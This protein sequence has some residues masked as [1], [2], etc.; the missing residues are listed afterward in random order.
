M[1]TGKSDLLIYST[2]QNR[3]GIVRSNGDGTFNRVYYGS[4]EGIGVYSL[5]PRIRYETDR[6]GYP[7]PVKDYFR[8]GALALD[9]NGDGKRDLF[10]YQKG[11]GA[12]Q[13]GPVQ[14]RW[15]LYQG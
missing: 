3:V 2:R 15:N 14:W 5:G 6:D 12:H 8:S 11:T 9:Y 4:A 1:A 7:Q 13:R 10:F